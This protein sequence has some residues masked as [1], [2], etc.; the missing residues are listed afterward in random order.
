MPVGQQ[1][2][3]G[4]AWALTEW[5][6]G[7]R[8]HRGENQGQL[9]HFTNDGLKGEVLPQNLRAGWTRPLV[10]LHNQ[11]VHFCSPFWPR[12]RVLVLS[13]GQALT[14]QLTESKHLSILTAPAVGV[15][16]SPPF[17]FTI[18]NFFSKSDPRTADQNPTRA[19]LKTQVMGLTPR[20]VELVGM[21][22]DL[23][24]CI[25][26]RSLLG[27][28]CTIT[29]EFCCSWSDSGILVSMTQENFFYRVGKQNRN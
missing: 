14:P 12:Q 18:S 5:T 9:S 27:D 21:R 13:R 24:V 28:L 19:F 15:T 23:W 8:E 6:H 1:C 4:R 2:S 20:D 29:S 17:S 3:R 7:L 16:P 11:P 10:F 22:W 26:T 25:L